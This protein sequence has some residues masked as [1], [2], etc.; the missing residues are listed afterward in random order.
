MLNDIYKNKF[1]KDV[2]PAKKRG[3]DLSKL[4]GIMD[5]LVSEKPLSPRH[6]DHPLKGKYQG[7]RECKIEPNWLLIYMKNSVDIIFARTGT[8]SDLF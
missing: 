2:E 4:Y 1:H 7:F 5:L 8:H 3:K 6:D